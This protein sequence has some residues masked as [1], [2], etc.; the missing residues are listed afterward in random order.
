MMLRRI[1]EWF[2]RKPSLPAV[3]PELPSPMQNIRSAAEEEANF[4]P[5]FAAGP[6]GRHV[7]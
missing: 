6:S 1:V 7:D 2:N 5:K 4:W 3:R